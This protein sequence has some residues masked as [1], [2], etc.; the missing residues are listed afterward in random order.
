MDADRDILQAALCRPRDWLENFQRRT[1]PEAFRDYQARFAPAYRVAVAETA[2][3]G[4]AQKA[5]AEELLAVLDQERKRRPFWD[6][7]ALAV[8]Q[9]QLAAIYF[10]PMLLALDMEEGR[11]FCKLFRDAWTARWPKETYGIT[12]AEN[13]Q[14]GFKT[15]F[16]GIPLERRQEKN[17]WL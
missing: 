7:G 15:T 5:L 1:Y 11:E 3:D 9:R 16:M 14:T 6:R 13:I 4:D 17:D 8:D 2:G 10:S 12:T